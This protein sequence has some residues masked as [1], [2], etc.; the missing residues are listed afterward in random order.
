MYSYKKAYTDTENE[1][2]ES[3]RGIVFS[4]T[5]KF[6]S[7]QCDGPIEILDGMERDGLC[8]SAFLKSFNMDGT[9]VRNSVASRSKKTGWGIFGLK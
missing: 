4:G 5:C 9:K 2:V 1:L 6:K 7:S 8:T 3:I